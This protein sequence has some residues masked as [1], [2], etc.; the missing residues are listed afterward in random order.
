MSEEAFQRV[1]D[2]IVKRC[3]EVNNRLSDSKIIENKI[4]YSYKIADSCHIFQ[5]K[6]SG[7]LHDVRFFSKIS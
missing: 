2:V 7:R 4:S 3:L 6:G 5:Q 1:M